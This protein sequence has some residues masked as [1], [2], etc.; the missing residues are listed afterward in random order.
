MEVSD[1]VV[2]EA[3]CAVVSMAAVVS[4]SSWTTVAS[5][6]PELQPAPAWILQALDGPSPSLPCAAKGAI[7]QRV[8]TP[9]GNCR[10]SR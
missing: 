9:P 3:L 2:Q 5:Q 6:A 8:R 7:P 4:Q 10:S 1:A